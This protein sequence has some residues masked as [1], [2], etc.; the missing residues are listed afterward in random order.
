[1]YGSVQ[2]MYGSVHS[3]DFKLHGDG[4][5]VGWLLSIRLSVGM[6]R[7][8]RRKVSGQQRGGA[9][10]TGDVAFLFRRLHT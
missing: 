4:S 10:L 1:M 9:I 3:V 6:S 7:F 8:G 2:Y 5:A